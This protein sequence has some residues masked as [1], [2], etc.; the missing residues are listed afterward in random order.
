VASLVVK[1]ELDQRLSATPVVTGLTRA[2][3]NGRAS[4]S[5]GLLVSAGALAAVGA[6]LAGWALWA[7]G[8]EPEAE[9]TP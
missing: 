6:G 3:A 8:A 7:P 9:Q 1:G 5:N 4:L 2:E